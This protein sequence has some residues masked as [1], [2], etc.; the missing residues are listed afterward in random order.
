MCS[1]LFEQFLQFFLFDPDKFSLTKEL[2]RKI[3]TFP[4]DA[5]PNLLCKSVIFYRSVPW[6]KLSVKQRVS[7]LFSIT[8]ALI[9]SLSKSIFTSDFR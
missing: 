5:C 6:F 4:S 8:D 3:S 1:Q 9:V 2:S 7:I